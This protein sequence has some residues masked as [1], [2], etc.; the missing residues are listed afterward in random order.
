MQNVYQNENH[1]QHKHTCRLCKQFEPDFYFQSK[2]PFDYFNEK[3]STVFLRQLYSDR[4][5]PYY[6]L[7]R[8]R[9]NWISPCNC[10]GKKVHAYCYT[11][12]I[13]HDKVIN[14]TKCGCY[15]KLSIKK[16]KLF[17]KEFTAVLLKY[18]MLNVVLMF[19]A[20]SFL[21]FDAYLKC[22]YAKLYPDEIE[23]HIEKLTTSII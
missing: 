8:V 15:Y 3:K 2:N 10:V 18:T 21:V 22:E 14:C 7:I 4:S 11:A 16:E 19:M 9:N 20:L 23:A 5:K 13:L 12:K 17:N 6:K 1:S